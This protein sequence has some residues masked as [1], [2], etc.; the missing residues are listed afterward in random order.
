MINGA[1]KTE[2]HE[3]TLINKHGK[4]VYVGRTSITLCQKET[5]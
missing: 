3:Q 4:V 1:G 5:P 2:V